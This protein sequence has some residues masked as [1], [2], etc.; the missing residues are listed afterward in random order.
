MAPL[1]ASLLQ[2]E[3]CRLLPDEVQSS[4]GRIIG[5]ISMSLASLGFVKAALESLLMQDFPVK[6]KKFA[7]LLCGLDDLRT[8]K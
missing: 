8:D 5:T 4:Q 7:L 3:S 1:S 2:N 6:V